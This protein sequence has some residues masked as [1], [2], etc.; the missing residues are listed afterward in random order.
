M[1]ILPSKF[2]WNSFKCS[3]TNFIQLNLKNSNL[4]NSNILYNSVKK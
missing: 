3:T 1:Q 2:D 4:F